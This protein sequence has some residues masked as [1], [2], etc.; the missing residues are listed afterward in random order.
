[1]TFRLD[2]RIPLV[3]RSPDELQ[4]GV[5]RAVVRLQKVTRADERMI[6]ALK[7]GITRS[8]LLM[9]GASEGASEADLDTLLDSVSDALV[10]VGPVTPPSRPRVCIDGRGEAARQ[11][12]ALLQELGCDVETVQDVA[13]VNFAV[14][15]AHYV[16]DPQRYGHWLR[17][18]IPHL[19]VVFTDRGCEIGPVVEP[20]I[21]PCLYCIELNRT[22][23][24]PQW[25]AMATQLVSRKAPTEEALAIAELLGFVARL[26]LT[27]L[28]SSGFDRSASARLDATSMYR[29]TETG[30]STARRHSLHPKCGCQSLPETAMVASDRPAGVRTQTSS[31]AGADGRE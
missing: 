3:W 31:G 20:G 17:R 10:P 2:P 15:I 4:L 8:G 13:P 21:G 22:D 7:A 28:N 29:E 5:D 25:P 1:M 14:I 24:D 23:L 30:R 18:D 16:I 19:A 9:L 27:R 11:L 26:V 12:A 6:T